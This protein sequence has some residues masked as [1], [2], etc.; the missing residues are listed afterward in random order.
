MPRKSCR[1]SPEEPLDNDG[2]RATFSLAELDAKIRRDERE[3][4]AKR[5]AFTPA[6]Y[7]KLCGAYESLQHMNRFI[8]E[9]PGAGASV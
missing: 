7:A 8:G 1:T 3:A 2:E 9:K 6:E 5:E 4:R